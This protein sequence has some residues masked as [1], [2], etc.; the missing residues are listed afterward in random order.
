VKARE[1]TGVGVY[2]DLDVDPAALRVPFARL[3]LSDVE[4]LIGAKHDVGFNLFVTDGV[5]DTLEGFSYDDA[6]P[7]VVGEFELRHSDP[8]RTGVLT[9]LALAKP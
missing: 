3:V 4:A 2:V 8:R 7:E 9:Q 6:W 5:I 1:F